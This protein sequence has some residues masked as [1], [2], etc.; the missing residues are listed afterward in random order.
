[1][2]SNANIKSFRGSNEAKKN[3]MS[4]ENKEREIVEK[5]SSIIQFFQQELI[6]KV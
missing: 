5:F 2:I 6:R 1:L 4:Y 3:E